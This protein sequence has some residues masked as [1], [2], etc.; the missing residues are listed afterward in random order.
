MR[1]TH[2]HTERETEYDTSQNRLEVMLSEKAPNQCGAVKTQN[3]DRN[4][5]YPNTS[6][7]RTKVC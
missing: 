5:Q 7:S 6:T 4:I 3:K 2:T 1:E